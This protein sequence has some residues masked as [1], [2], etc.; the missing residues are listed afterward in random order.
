MS[1]TITSPELI[2]GKMIPK[3][4]TVD[5]DDV[6][7]PLAWHQVPKGTKE[8][9]IVCDDP[10]A[11]TAQ[12]WVHWLI[13]QIPPSVTELP[14]GLPLQAVLESPVAALQG[15]NSWSSGRTIGYRGPAPPRG[16]GLHHYHIRLHAIDTELDLGPGIEKEQLMEAM[17]G[18]ILEQAE[19]IGTYQR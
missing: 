8:L 12:P 18:H 6:S 16:D 10:D 9:A 13:Y 2:D 7:P 4:F 17:A 3:R 14:E 11:P 5:G 15:C 1:L 19:I